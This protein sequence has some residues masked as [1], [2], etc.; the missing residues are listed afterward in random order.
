MQTVA[1]GIGHQAQLAA[2]AE[3]DPGAAAASM[4]QR[5]RDG[6]MNVSSLVHPPP[7]GAP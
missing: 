1:A 3:A 5:L 2:L 7:T 4:I 6:S